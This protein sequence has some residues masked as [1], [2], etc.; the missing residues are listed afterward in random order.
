[1]TEHTLGHCFGHGTTDAYDTDPTTPGWGGLGDYG[2][3]AQSIC[4]G[5]IPL[6][7]AA[8]HHAL[9]LKATINPL[10]LGDSNQVVAQPVQNQA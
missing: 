5:L 7:F 4:H 10:H 3:V 9:F 6:L 2:I 1:M 8:F